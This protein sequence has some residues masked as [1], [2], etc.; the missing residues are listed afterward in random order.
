MKIKPGLYFVFA[1]LILV[2]CK[3][4][5]LD[6]QEADRSM[7]ILNSNLMNLLTAGSEKPEFQAM[8]FLFNQEVSP[9]PFYKT[10]NQAVPDTVTYNIE[11]NKGNYSWD[12]DTK[13]FKKTENAD[14]ISL[15]FPLS[16]SAAN[17]IRFDLIHYKSQ[18]Y[19][20]RPDLP[21]LVDAIISDADR[22]LA[23][24]KHTANITNNLPENISTKIIG[25]DYEAAFELRRTQLKN[26]GKLMIDLFLK[27]KGFEVISGHVDAEIEY[28][29]QG[30][31]F[32][33]IDFYLKLQDH[34][35][36]G[37]IKYSEINPTAADYIDS[38][39]SNSS[40]I[41]SEG[42]NQVGKIVLN[43]TDNKE[44]LDYYI[45]FS[46][47]SETLLSTYIPVLKKLLNL[48]Y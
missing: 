43:K 28:S 20:S 1:F 22:Q 16:N 32:K 34:H 11:K 21:V 29:R 25:L 39:N 44:L 48:K 18:A 46:D 47:G 30:Y 41:L 24:L 26:D 3:G 27:T 45:R 6:R 38:F 2:S 9:L 15:N 31:F 35:V 33:T 7:K 42:K 17:T 19:S 37:K 4:K 10:K 8:E 13:R 40:I 23:G 36:T 5:I 14:R 12:S